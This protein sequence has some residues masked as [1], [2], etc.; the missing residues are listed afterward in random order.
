[1]AIAEG[2]VWLATAY[3]ALGIL[4]CVPFLAVGARRIDPLAAGGTWGFRVLVAPGVVALWPLLARRWLAGG[5]PPT[6]RTPHEARTPT[7]TGP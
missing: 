4:F 5:R 6:E 2:L 3:V 7:E 1:M